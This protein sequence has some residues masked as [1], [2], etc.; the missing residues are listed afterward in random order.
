[1]EVT[2][3]TVRVVAILGISKKWNIVPED[4]VYVDDDIYVRLR[5]CSHTLASLVL[6]NNPDAPG[7]EGDINFRT[8]LSQ[9]TGFKQLSDEK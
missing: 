4:V 7:A 3:S 8:Q 5:S 9:C 1:M 6:A 2:L